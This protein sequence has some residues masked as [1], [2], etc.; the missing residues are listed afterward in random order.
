MNSMLPELIDRFRG[1]RVLVLGESMLDTYLRGSAHRLCREAPVPI[2]ALEQRDHAPGGAANTARNL[3]SLA[4]EVTLLSVVGD[5]DEGRLLRADLEA[6]GI[7]VEHVLVRSS[8][9]TPSKNRIVADGQILVRF[10]DGT[11]GPLEPEDD[12]DLVDRLEAL[13]HRFDALL[14]S[15]YGYGIV[16]SRILEALA[17]LQRRQP[18]LVVAD[19]K[20]LRRY[21]DVGVTAVKPNYGEALALLGE[22]ELDEQR[23]RLQQI[24]SNAPRLLEL[25]G[26][27]IAAVTLDTDGALVF[28]SGNPPYRT[29]ARPVGHSRAAGAGD[30]FA[31]AFTLGLAA[32]AGT[33]TAAELASAAA[34]VVVGKEGTAACSLDELRACFLHDDKS[35]DDRERLARR[36]ASYR[37][38]G[39]RIV[40][41]NGCFD[42]LHRGH[43]TYLNRAKAL[44][45]VLVVG[46]NTDESVR[47]LKGNARPINSLEDRAQ[48]LAALSCIDHLVTFDED[49][50]IELI[51]VV[52]PHVFV[53]GGDYTRER[54]PEAPI[55]EALGGVVQILPYIEDRSTTNVIERIRGAA[56]GVSSAADG[57]SENDGTRPPGSPAPARKV[58]AHSGRSPTSAA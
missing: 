40:F 45:D 8:R 17:R 49:T 19:A 3:R 5:D 43:I 47:R 10:D 4:A 16:T 35:I 30:T 24:A 36:M 14:V 57:S 41:T 53:K 39:R 48:V 26:A 46:V 42:I 55:V 1:L 54:L 21:R 34:A 37:E 27:R 56:A 9:R 12:E 7:D 33:T 32:G 11:T 20:D 23:V 29:Y 22:R 25:T 50:P 31:A 18:R 52:R 28:E 15:D 13:H 51:K 6:R 58:I 44:G 2:V 38:Q